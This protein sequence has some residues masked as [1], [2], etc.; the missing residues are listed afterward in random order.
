MGPTWGPPGSC[1]PQIGPMLTPWT[2]L[3]RIPQ[4][5]ECTVQWLDNLCLNIVEGQGPSDVGQRNQARYLYQL[6][7]ELAGGCCTE[8]QLLITHKL[9]TPSVA[10]CP[11]TS[12]AQLETQ[13]LLSWMFATENGRVRDNGNSVRWPYDWCDLCTDM[14]L[15]DGST[16]WKQW[17]K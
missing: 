11:V 10:N 3:W 1:Q 6:N 8:W 4:D 14:K 7:L 5:I 12:L 9:H 13:K 2:L 16:C 17:W 15:T